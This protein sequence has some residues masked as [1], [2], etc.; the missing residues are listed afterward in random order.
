[1]SQTSHPLTKSEI[2]RNSDEDYGWMFDCIANMN[3]IQWHDLKYVERSL[4][5][6]SYQGNLFAFVFTDD[7]KNLRRHKTEYI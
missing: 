5:E 2:L 7:F 6:K 1:M 3:M 4:K